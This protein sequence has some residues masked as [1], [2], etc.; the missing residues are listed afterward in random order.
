M[1]IQYSIDRYSLPKK[2]HIIPSAD[3]DPAVLAKMASHLT[4][5]N[6]AIQFSEWA[7]EGKLDAF[8]DDKYDKLLAVVKRLNLLFWNKKTKRPERQ[9]GLFDLT[10]QLLYEYMLC[11]ISD[12]SRIV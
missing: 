2:I 6:P 5:E 8:D 11:H 9:V 4:I 1:Q 10:I 3:E 12:N 7:K